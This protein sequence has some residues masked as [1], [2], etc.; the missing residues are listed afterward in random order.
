EGYREQGQEILPTY[1]PYIHFSITSAANYIVRTKWL[2]EFVFYAAFKGLK[3]EPVGRLNR[4]G[5][6]SVNFL[7][8]YPVD[9]GLSIK[10]NEIV[11]FLPRPDISDRNAQLFRDGYDDSA[12]CR[13]V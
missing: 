13:S 8:D 6:Q 12:L 3:A 10:L 4:Q 2:E 1:L 7:A 9:I 11:Q 5:C